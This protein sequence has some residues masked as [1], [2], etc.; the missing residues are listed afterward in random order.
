MYVHPWPSMDLLLIINS[1]WWVFLGRM[2]SRFNYLEKS[3][4]ECLPPESPLHESCASRPAHTI[5]SIIPPGA[6]PPYFWRQTWF[7]QI[8]TDTFCKIDGCGPSIECK[9]FYKRLFLASIVWLYQNEINLY[10]TH[11]H[12]D[13]PSQQLFRIVHHSFGF[14]S[15]GKLLAQFCCIEPVNRA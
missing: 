4:S 2:N 9:T 8:G 1:I 12:E 10:K 3:H 14:V 5:E 15:E 7:D 6:A 13:C 11:F